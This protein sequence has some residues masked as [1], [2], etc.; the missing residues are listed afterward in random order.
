MNCRQSLLLLLTASLAAMLVA[1]GTS[2]NSSSQQVTLAYS[3]LQ[4]TPPSSMTAGATAPIAVTITNG[5]ANSVVNWTVTCS[6]ASCG[7][8]NP[9]STSS[10]VVTTYTAPSS[11]PAAG[12][13]V[14]VTATYSGTGTATPLSSSITVNAATVS[15]AYTSGFAPPAS[16]TAGT[17][18]GIA[19]TITN[20]SAGSV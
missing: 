20:G 4:D 8:F 19:V 5:S 18:A 3:A 11:V 17:T 13:T 2:N 14:N 9:T 12:L 15:L 10:T 1:C 16:M 7:T 6:Q